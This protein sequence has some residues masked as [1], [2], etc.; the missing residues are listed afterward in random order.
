MKSNKNVVKTFTPGEKPLEAIF[1]LIEVCRPYGKLVDTHEELTPLSLTGTQ[2]EQMVLVLLDGVMSII[3]DSD[4]LLYAVVQGPTFIGVLASDY[5]KEINTF[6]ASKGSEVMVL[7]RDT[8]I[9]LITRHGLV[10]ELLDYYRYIIDYQN[11]IAELMI[12]RSTYEIVC[13]L[14]HELMLLPPESRMKISVSNYISARTHLA[15]SGI[16]KILA[17]LRLGEYIEIKNGKLKGI[18]KNFPLN[19]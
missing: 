2:G 12:S 6:C 10:R 4:Q 19:Y 18:I 16:M 7:S 14:L 8:V 11:Y 15:R 1:R 9:D 13:G 17:D 3:R 5:R